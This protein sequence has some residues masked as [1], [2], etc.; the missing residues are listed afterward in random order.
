VGQVY[1][2]LDELL[3]ADKFEVARKVNFYL[4]AFVTREARV[5]LRHAA[6][7]RCL[8]RGQQD[9]DGGRCVGLAGRAC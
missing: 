5:T 3:L 2:I 7:P 1:V 6:A 9:N 8:V 4:R